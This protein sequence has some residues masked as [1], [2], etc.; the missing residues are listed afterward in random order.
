FDIAARTFIAGT[1]TVLYVLTRAPSTS[2]DAEELVRRLRADR[3]VAEGRVWVGGQTANNLDAM[4]FIQAHTPPALGFLT[5]VAAP[6]PCL[7]LGSEVRRPKALVMDLLSIA[8]SFGALVWIFQEGHLRN[9]LRFE[10]GPIEPS[11]PI[12]LFCAVFGLSM[13]YEVLLLSRIQE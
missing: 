5:P 11:L 3:S 12:L 6:V 2:P 8:G 1:V 10:P 13:D 7:L 4:A 9:L